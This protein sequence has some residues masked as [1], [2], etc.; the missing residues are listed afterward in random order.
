MLI[1]RN[2]ISNES[3]GAAT[4]IE[5]SSCGSA[6]IFGNVLECARVMRAA[7]VTLDT[8]DNANIENNLML[9]YQSEFLLSGTRT[10]GVDRNAIERTADGIRR[11]VVVD[12]R[13]NCSDKHES[14]AGSERL[15]I[16]LGAVSQMLRFPCDRPTAFGRIMIRTRGPKDERVRAACGGGQPVPC[17]NEPL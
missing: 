6:T 11:H 9:G 14:L 7:A 4:G 12:Q 8:V 5:L 13:T 15:A 1:A 10:S 16:E 3:V 2:T 17:L